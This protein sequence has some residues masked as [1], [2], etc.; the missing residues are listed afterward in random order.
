MFSIL[1]IYSNI[2]FLQFF[3]FK[4]KKNKIVMIDHKKTIID[5]TI[6]TRTFQSNSAINVEVRHSQTYYGG[7]IR[8]L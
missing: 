2:F 3:D 5:H 4:K 1:K 8:F 6:L 7:S